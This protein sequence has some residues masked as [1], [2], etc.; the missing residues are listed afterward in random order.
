VRPATKGILVRAL[1]LLTAVAAVI[2]L[3][4]FAFLEAM[5]D[6]LP[7]LKDGSEDRIAAYLENAGSARGLLALALLQFIQVVS[8]IPSSLPIQIAAGIV[9]GR[10][11]GFLVCHAA[12][13]IAHA[14]V[15]C[16]ARKLD[17]KLDGWIPLDR[18]SSR[19]DFMERSDFPAY[20]TVIAC[21]VPFIPNGILPYAAARTRMTARQ[22]TLCILAGNCIPV[23]IYCSIGH[24]LLEG[25]YLAATILFASLF[26]VSVILFRFRNQVLAFLR[27]HLPRL[28]AVNR[29][30]ERGGN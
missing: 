9:Y 13:T 15:F 22:Y 8:V 4:Y 26:A 7:L 28:F 5:P 2:L 19:L 12:S 11:R 3:V 24:I 25:G 20:M 16:A 18:R 29:D 6:L 1:I 17:K 21:L 14:A 27:G 10:L 30:N 23:L